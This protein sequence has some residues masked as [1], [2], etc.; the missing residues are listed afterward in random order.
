MC[1]WWVMERRGYDRLMHILCVDLGFCGCIKHERPM[2]VDLLIPPEGPVTAD[3]FVDW[4]FLAD[5]LN[6]NSEKENGQPLKTAIRTAFVECMGAEVVDASRL[7][8]S[9]MGE[10][11]GVADVKRR[12]LLD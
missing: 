12:G 2:H 11:P 8:W 7:R 4:V 5:D 10:E 3:Q 9:F 6:P 1:E